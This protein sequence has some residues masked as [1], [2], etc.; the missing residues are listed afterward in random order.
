MEVRQVSPLLAT[1]TYSASLWIPP[2][3]LL[4]PEIKATEVHFSTIK[5]LTPLR[6]FWRMYNETGEMQRPTLSMLV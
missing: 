5:R 3:A 2:V 4:H 1:T 6:L